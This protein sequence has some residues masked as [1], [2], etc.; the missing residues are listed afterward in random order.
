[1][2]RKSSK[3]G[4]ILFICIVIII[5]VAYFAL[6]FYYAQGFS[7]GTWINDVYCTGKS[8][9][10]I[11]EQMI[12]GHSFDDFVIETLDGKTEIIS[13]KDIG[14]Q[15]DFEDSLNNILQEQNPFLWYENL[16]FQGKYKVVPNITYNDDLLQETIEQLTVIQQEIK[17]PNKNVIIKLG[18]NGYEIIDETKNVL[19][20]DK[21]IQTITMAIKEGKTSISLVEEQCYKDIPLTIEQQMQYMIWEKVDEFQSFLMLYDFGD[22]VE[23]VNKSIVSKWITMEDEENTIFA[24]DEDLNLIIDELKVEQY[25][26]Q[27]A[28][29][30]DTY[31]VVRQFK[32]TRGD[33]VVIDG[34]TYGNQLNVKKETQY[35]LEAFENKILEPRVPEYIHKALFQGKNDIGD[36]YIEID[37]KEQELYFYEKGELKIQTPVVTGNS[38]W[39]LET[40]AK[41]CAVVGKYKNTVLRGPDYASQVDFWVPVYKNIGI[42]D[43]KWRSEFGGEIYKTN[44]SHGCINV[45]RPIMEELFAKFEVGMPV[46]MY[47]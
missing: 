17:N 24:F 46:V 42:H 14:Y 40:P 12:D 31:N 35:L 29:K 36:T 47:Y 25:V 10:E 37:L 9:N 34:G 8:I 20:I 18:E 15:I 2:K 5:S 44:G 6:G 1:M 16:I 26:T 38:K 23:P 4:I 33:M 28:E 30:Y 45:P 22:T 13:R 3:N 19:N 32:S 27:L 41:A 11:N 39:K 21:A 43:A 7:Y